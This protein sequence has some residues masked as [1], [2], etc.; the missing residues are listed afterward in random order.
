[1]KGLKFIGLFDKILCM[2][3]RGKN[4]IS[5]AVLKDSQRFQFSSKLFVFKVI[6]FA[7]GFPELFY[8]QC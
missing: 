7:G 5:L 3:E 8:G 2:Y 4:P 6:Y 1:M